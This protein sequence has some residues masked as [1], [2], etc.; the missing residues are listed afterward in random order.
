M[1][2]HEKNERK[3]W[4]ILLLSDSHFTILTNKCQMSET[5]THNRSQFLRYV[6]VTERQKHKQKIEQ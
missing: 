4:I 6:Q 5:V 3:I 1:D 2:Q